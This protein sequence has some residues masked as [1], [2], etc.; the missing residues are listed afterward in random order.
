VKKVLADAIDDIGRGTFILAAEAGASAL[1]AALIP[2]GGAI[3]AVIDLALAEQ[4]IELLYDMPDDIANQVVTSFAFDCHR[5]FPGDTHCVDALGREITDVDSDNWADAPGDGRTVSPD[6]IHMFWDAPGPSDPREQ[7]RGIYGYNEPVQ[8]VVG[9][10]RRPRCEILP[11][12]G[13][14][15]IQGFVRFRGRNVRDAY[16]KAN[17]HHTTSHLS[18]PG[19]TLPVRAGGRYKVVARYKDP[20]TKKTV[21]GER[22]TGKPSDPPMAPGEVLNLDIT[23]SE[24]PE[25]M[26][27]VTVTGQ[28]RVDDVYLTGADHADTFY[29]KTLYVQWGVAH[30]NEGTGTWDVDPDDP[31]AIARR[32]DVAT[33]GA[34]VG[35]SNGGLT[36]EVSANADL[37]I[38]VTLTGTLNPGDDDLSQVQTVNVPKDATV[39]VPEFDLDTGGPFNDRAYF[40]GIT[41]SNDAAQAI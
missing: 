39:T 6:N 16:V 30:F 19:Y 11:S 15:T 13:V 24:P 31:A 34:S 18:E 25:C 9:V 41:I 21:Y 28:V 29:S 40:R 38:D 33:T 27:H 17:C 4:L 12:T 8:P 22:V 26:R 32:K 1:V 10:V 23:L 35:D 7:L 2:L 37:S 3:V 5:G 36:I 14:A 20:V